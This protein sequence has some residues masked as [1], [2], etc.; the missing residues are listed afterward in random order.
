MFSRSTI[1]FD[2]LVTEN[3]ASNTVRF[4]HPCSCCFQRT[5]EH[6]NLFGSWLRWV[7]YRANDNRALASFREE[8]SLNVLA[9]GVVSFICFSIPLK[10]NLKIVLRV[11]YG[12]MSAPGTRTSNLVAAGGTTGGDMMRTEHARE[13]KPYV[14]ALGAQKASPPIRRLYPL[15]VGTSC[16]VYERLPRLTTSHQLTIGIT[17]NKYQPSLPTNPYNK[18]QTDHLVVHPVILPEIALLAAR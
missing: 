9:G 8:A 14:T 18:T 3:F 15:T 11:K 17:V 2:E 13:S 10:P 12:F 7:S 4:H 16:I 1:V 6:D 5:W